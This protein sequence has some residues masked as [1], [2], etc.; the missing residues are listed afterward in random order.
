[1]M[2][3]PRDA[4]RFEETP[5][6]VWI[7]VLF[8]PLPV[9]PRSSSSVFAPTTLVLRVVHAREAPSRTRGRTMGAPSH[10]RCAPT[11]GRS[12]VHLAPIRGRS[13]VAPGLRRVHAGRS[14]PRAC[15]SR[16]RSPSARAE[17]ATATNRGS[18]G[19]ARPHR[20]QPILLGCGPTTRSLRAGS[21]GC[22]RSRETHATT[23]ADSRSSVMPYSLP[24]DSPS[25]RRSNVRVATPHATPERLTEADERRVRA[26]SCTV[27]ISRRAGRASRDRGT[28][29]GCIRRA[30]AAAPVCGTAGRRARTSTRYPRRCGAA[31]A[32]GSGHAR[33]RGGIRPAGAPQSSRRATLQRA[34]DAPSGCA[35]RAPCSRTV[36][37]CGCSGP[38]REPNPSPRGDV[39]LACVVRPSGAPP[40][41]AQSLRWLSC[42]W[43]VAGAGGARDRPKLKVEVGQVRERAAWLLVLVVLLTGVFGS[44]ILWRGGADGCD[45]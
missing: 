31:S 40:R 36:G 33:C 24:V 41:R 44:A 43:L 10:A 9:S 38:A 5:A 30:L 18:T 20:R 27:R 8:A 29:F 39:N 14:R 7:S 17:G 11:G 25:T 15:G 34:R 1:M 4:R 3:R 6:R 21:P 2:T 35:T 32:S 42:T 26:R 37:Q 13:A 22:A 12:G 28:R 45:H 19:R 23:S 16:R